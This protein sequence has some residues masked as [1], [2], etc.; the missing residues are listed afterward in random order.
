MFMDRRTIKKFQPGRVLDGHVHDALGVPEPVWPYS[1]HANARDRLRDWLKGKKATVYL[2]GERR[3]SDDCVLLVYGF[4]ESFEAVSENHAL[5]LAVLLACYL[6]E[7][8][9]HVTYGNF[10]L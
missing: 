9:R 10:R 6:K 3:A 8:G 5:C 1:T 2:P 7:H 4:R